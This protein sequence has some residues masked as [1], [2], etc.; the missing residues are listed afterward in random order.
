MG[1]ANRNIS[2][3]L[4]MNLKPQLWT[5]LG[6]F[7]ACFA[8]FSGLFLVRQAPP[9]IDLIA[10]VLMLP[11]LSGAAIVFPTGTDSGYG[12]AYIWLSIVINA[13]VY[14]LPVRWVLRSALTQWV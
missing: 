2:C 9:T 1:P 4:A 6:A 10:W 7:S 8:F 3:P 5:F 12:D 14:A 13:F 11:G